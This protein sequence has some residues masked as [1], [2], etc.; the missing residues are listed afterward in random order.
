MMDDATRIAIE[1][2]MKAWDPIDELVDDLQLACR[3]KRCTPQGIDSTA[4]HRMDI[5]IQYLRRELRRLDLEELN[6]KAEVS[7]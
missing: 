6:K 3:V 7:A 1:N 2:V 4:P 5:A